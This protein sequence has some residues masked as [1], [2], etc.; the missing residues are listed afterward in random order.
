MHGTRII[1]LI[2]AAAL[3]LAAG[4]CGTSSTTRVVDPTPPDT[5]F[6]ELS[7]GTPETFDVV[8]W[9]IENFTNDQDADPNERIRHVIDA[10]RALDADVIARQEIVSNLSF[11]SVLEELPGWDGFRAD[12]YWGSQQL[13][14]LC[15]RPRSR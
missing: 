9:N 11:Q 15:G 12:Q 3:A 13:A 6:T 5:L 8:T 1:I 14:Y 2:G 7:F 4:G 10:V